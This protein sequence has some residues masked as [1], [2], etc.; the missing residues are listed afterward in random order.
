MSI[1]GNY[2][3]YVRTGGRS[4]AAYSDKHI[5]NASIY[6]YRPVVPENVLRERE[7]RMLS[8][9]RSA[10]EKWLGNPPPGR[11]GLDQYRQ[12]ERE[13]EAR[14]RIRPSISAQ[15]RTKGEACSASGVKVG[16]LV[17]APSG[18]RRDLVPE[19]RFPPPD[20]AQAYAAQVAEAIARLNDP[21]LTAMQRKAYR[22]LAEG[23]SWIEVAF[24]LSV[25]ASQLKRESRESDPR[26][27][28]KGQR[29][30]RHRRASASST[31]WWKPTRR[32]NVLRR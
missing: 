28:R 2:R 13:R 19:P 20:R 23:W 14:E 29:G 22:L 7:Q 27:H 30:T 24:E 15:P 9:N 31:P 16:G 26:R 18:P 1:T 12:R 8:D 5:T 25:P 6:G 32:V 10:L 17:T 3:H 4:R 21:T 11:S